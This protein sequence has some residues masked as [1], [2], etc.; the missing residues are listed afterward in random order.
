MLERVEVERSKAWRSVEVGAIVAV[1]DVSRRHGGKQ[2]IALFLLSNKS[3]HT[4]AG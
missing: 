1:V 4:A 2:S 3:S